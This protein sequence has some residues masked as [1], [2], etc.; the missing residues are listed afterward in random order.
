M[1]LKGETIGGFLLW[2]LIAG[3]LI[4]YSAGGCHKEPEAPAVQPTPPRPRTFEG[5]MGMVIE[6]KVVHAPD[7]VYLVDSTGAYLIR[8]TEAVRVR[9]VP[10]FTPPA[11][12]P[13]P[14]E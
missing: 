13:A 1:K 9:E 3:S 8:G 5:A 12:R 2:A 7:G 6:T 4:A 10:A 14:H 11:S